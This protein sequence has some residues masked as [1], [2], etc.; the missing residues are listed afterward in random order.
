MLWNNV[1]NLGGNFLENVE[2]EFQSSDSVTIASG[3]VSLDIIKKFYHNFEKIADEGGQARLLVGMAFY[4]GL[5]ANKLTLL[6]NL[7]AKLEN[8]GT[9]SG[10]FVSCNGRYHGK[11]YRFG[12]GE[13]KRYYIGSSNFSRSGLAE[14][15]E[16]TAIIND[17]LIK[18]KLG[19]FV[20][21]LFLEENAVSILKA[22]IIVPGTREYSSK[23]SLKTLDDLSRYDP[24]TIDK[25]VLPKLEFPLSRIADKEK[26]NLNVYFGKGR[27]SR[28]TGKVLARDWYEVELIANRAITSSLL[29]PKGDF[30]AYTDDGF[31]IPMKT[32]GDYFKNIRSRGNLSILGQWIK[33][34]LQKSGVLIP[35]TPVTQ[36][37]LDA[38]GRNTIN[39]YKISDGNYYMEF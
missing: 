32:S 37:T 10:V 9:G 1:G 31:I 26:S 38:H 34:K 30:T 19:K 33:G 22:D 21:Y 28:A 15:I 8:T 18:K 17:D 12:S 16:C 24:D 36:D 11:L 4:E 20:D 25:T 3:Y 7:S 14:N 5:T 13:N 23:I 39:F 2:S 29:Y 27:W 35:L 6:N